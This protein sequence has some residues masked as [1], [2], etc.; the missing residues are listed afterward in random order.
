MLPRRTIIRFAR[1]IP[2]IATVLL[3]LINGVG[4]AA[5]VQENPPG[6]R[7]LQPALRSRVDRLAEQTPLE[8]VRQGKVDFAGNVAAWLI[9]Q[10]T[11][12]PEQELRWATEAHQKLLKQ[13][14]IVPTPTEAERVFGKLLDALPAHLKPA[15]FRY[16][17]TVI[18]VP[19]SGAFTVGGGYVYVT[20]PLLDNFLADKERGP[21][22]L[23][24]ALAHELG[25]IAYLHCRQ[26]YQLIQLGEQ[27]Q[28]GPQANG[29]VKL[30]RSVLQTGTNSAEHLV[31]FLFTRGQE[32]DADLFALHLCRNSEVD[33]DVAL[34]C[35]RWLALWRYPRIA[36]DAAY[37]P[38][39]RDRASV[40]AYY[41]SSHPDPLCRLKRM[42]MELSGTVAE[43]DHYG[44]FRYDRAG[45][46]YTKAGR[47]PGDASKPAVVCVH[48]LRGDEHTFGDLLRFLG[49]QRALNDVPLYFFRYPNDSSLARSG[50]FLQNEV[51][52][53]FADGRKVIF[54]CHS[55]GGLVTRFYTERRQGAFDRVIFLGTPHH[56]SDLTSLKFLVDV[57][58]FL[59]ELK[60][61][62]ADALAA[63]IPEGRGDIVHDLHPDSLFL[64]HLGRDEKPA[65]RY[66]VFCADYLNTA[67]AL[68]LQ[69]GFGALK[70]GL[71]KRLAASKAPGTSQG[72][73]RYLDNLHLPA[74]IT[75]GDLV[76]SVRSAS[77]KGSASI[78]VLSGIN[79]QTLK[80]DL[81]V[82]EQVLQKI[83]G[84]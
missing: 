67:Q 39:E 15:A 59:R 78:T 22:A 72:A 1:S 64:R 70:Q 43:P 12:P 9:T 66:H 74:E 24:F 48:G 36:T 69:T 51:S 20:R 14:K 44:L 5:P 68:A 58:A 2:P 42:Q 21:A 55:A 83:E 31:K 41:L 52:R 27:V 26:G 47:S 32:Y 6:F 57:T 30:W 61:G 40:L 81:R 53:V 65:R 3:L 18:D 75:A 11:P 54:V 62:V 50:R 82:M 16:T 60:I 56:G 84:K 73:M 17:L 23:A 63:M 80:T 37:L 49:N 38:D 46:K 71:R 29:D 77:L 45:G 19:E 35:L 8:T 25:H 28:G 79:H 10:A 4:T 34:D 33:V 7:D 13:V 76:V